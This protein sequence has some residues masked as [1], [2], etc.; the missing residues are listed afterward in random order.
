M[1]TSLIV[2]AVLL[3]SC[4][5]ALA[6]V[7]RVAPPGMGTHTTLQAAVA[8]AADGDIVLIDPGH[9][10]GTA[11]VLISGLG[12]VL[13]SD[14]MSRA[15][16]PA[17]TITDLPQSSTLILRGLAFRSGVVDSFFGGLLDLDNCAGPVLI[18]D[19]VIAGV[20][21]TGVDG[22]NGGP[23]LAV[24]SCSGLTITRST[25][26]GGVGNSSVNDPPVV[27]VFAGH[28]A[29]ALRLQASSV[30]LAASMIHGGDGGNGVA[31][32]ANG[33]GGGLGIDAQNSTLYMSGT[34]ITGG[35]GGNGSNPGTSSFAAQVDG[36]TGLA[37]TLD[38]TL[39]GGTGMPGL[40]VVGGTE[41][42]WP[43]QALELAL[44]SPVRPGDAV[45]L[46]LAGPPGTLFGLFLSLDVGFLPLHGQHGVL[47]TQLSSFTGPVLVSNVPASG[48]L[49]LPITV[50]AVGGLDGFIVVGQALSQQAGVGL[51][52][53]SPSSWIQIENGL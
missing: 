47:A 17:T 8:D 43:G 10:L 34:T 15:E 11:P 18:E 50:P 16:L 31:T 40:V 14:G 51:V 7:L 38:S 3:G 27:L 35:D 42:A 32:G 4:P 26:T 25:L 28:G 53:S 1:R 12:L 52:W 29:R 9:D 6:D 19:C 39:T 13:V 36:L 24:A 23:G 37:V 5:S 21:G 49:N 20:D 41:L 30:L 44:P 46:S 33:G 45:A 48:L 22:K 2:F